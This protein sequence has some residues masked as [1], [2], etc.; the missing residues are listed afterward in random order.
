MADII[1]F[2]RRQPAVDDTL[3]IDLTTAVDA[4]IRDLRDI[5]RLRDLADIRAR[6]EECRAMLHKAFEND[7]VA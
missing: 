3:D 2:P 6:A 1:P 7:G 5:Q 4:A